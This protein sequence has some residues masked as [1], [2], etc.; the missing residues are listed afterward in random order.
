MVFILKNLCLNKSTVELVLPCSIIGN[1]DVPI[2]VVMS[3]H[4][5]CSCLLAGL[6]RVSMH[7]YAQETWLSRDIESLE[8]QS[9]GC[10]IQVLLERYDFEKIDLF[11]FE[12]IG[13]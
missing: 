2:C 10:Q 13:F 7:S 12:N 1:M 6:S 8:F 11:F 9:I 4:Y 3:N 5:F